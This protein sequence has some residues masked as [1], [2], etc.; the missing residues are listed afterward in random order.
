MRALR[1]GLGPH[2]PEEKKEGERMAAQPGQ[3]FVGLTGSFRDGFSAGR[4]DTILRL[5]AF[6]Q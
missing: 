5:S 3:Q 6:A 4:W 1:G 2:A